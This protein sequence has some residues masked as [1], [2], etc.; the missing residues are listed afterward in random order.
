MTIPKKN[1]HLKRSRLQERNA[2]SRLGGSI[3]SGSGNQWRRKND[4]RTDKESVEL[5]TTTKDSY[6]LRAEDLHKVVAN[7]LIDGAR[8]GWLEIEFANRGVTAVI[9]DAD[10]FYAIRRE[11]YE[12]KEEKNNEL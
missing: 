7:A 4:V 1:S 9:L 12:L 5:K 2:A 6:S 8:L 11:L 3:N 10:D